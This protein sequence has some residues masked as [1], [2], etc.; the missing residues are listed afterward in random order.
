MK[1]TK[2]FF[3]FVIATSIISCGKGRSDTPLNDDSIQYNL[4]RYSLMVGAQTNNCKL[5][6]NSTLNC[7]S[8]GKFGG[9]Y[10]IKFMTPKGSPGAYVVIPPSGDTYG[11][12]IMPADK[13]CE[14]AI[15]KNGEIYNCNFII[16]KK[17]IV[18]PGNTVY[19]E[20]NGSLGT[21]KIVAINIK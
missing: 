4:R 1:L 18:K 10:S 3:A 20:L 17:G 6:R 21:A 15:S 13:S 2:L 12:N 5:V 7:N 8:K 14:R 9:V 19:L 16:D 11:L